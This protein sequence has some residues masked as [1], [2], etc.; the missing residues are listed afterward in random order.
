MVE[1]PATPTIEYVSSG[2]QFEYSSRLVLAEY[3][4]SLHFAVTQLC[5]KPILHSYPFAPEP[6]AEAAVAITDNLGDL[7]RPC[8]LDGVKVDVAIE[9]A[10]AEG[11][12]ELLR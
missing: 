5:S 10:R 11:D 2:L 7:R 9:E 1:P 4:L 6:S 8:F 3:V 12:A